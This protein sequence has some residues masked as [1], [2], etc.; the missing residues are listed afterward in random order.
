MFALCLAVLMLNDQEGTEDSL[1]ATKASLTYSFIFDVLL[2]I[3][4]FV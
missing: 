2:L 1:F 4:L 3:A